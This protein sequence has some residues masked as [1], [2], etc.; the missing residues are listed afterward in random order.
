L[1][2]RR[3]IRGKQLLERGNSRPHL[4][5]NSLWKRLWT[6]RKTE[7][8]MMLFSEI[9]S[10]SLPSIFGSC[11]VFSLYLLSLSSFE[12]RWRSQHVIINRGISLAK[13][14]EASWVKQRWMKTRSYKPPSHM[15]KIHCGHLKFT[16]FLGAAIFR[17]RL[18][19]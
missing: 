11:N 10:P 5:E 15:T 17:L 14:G 19:A 7:H 12:I 2:E 13:W 9:T 16:R 18:S 8:V 1:T 4:V 3:G 6:R